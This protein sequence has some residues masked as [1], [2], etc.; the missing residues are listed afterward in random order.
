MT[1]L[2]LEARPIV[3][4]LHALL[5][6]LDPVRWQED[7]EAALGARLEEIREALLRLR[8]L[9]YPDDSLARLQSA[10]SDIEAVL[11]RHKA[12]LSARA[13]T[14]RE[15]WMGFRARLQP[16]YASIASSLRV[17]DVH[18]PA[19]RPTNYKRNALHACAGLGV[20]ALIVATPS[21]TVL[22]WLASGALIYFWT[23]ELLRRRRPKLNAK[24]MAIYGRFAHPHE[25]HR[26]ASSTWYCTS[27]FV[28]AMIGSSVAAVVAIL[29]LALAD[30]AAA[31]VGRRF[32]RIRLLHGR[33]LEG[34]L[35]FVGVG[36]AASALGLAVLFPAVGTGG[37]L[38][39]AAAGSV[40]GGA[41]ELLSRRVDDNLSIPVCAALAA[42]GVALLMGLPLN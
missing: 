10:I 2:A 15:E 18:V 38:A 11:V 3:L 36:G 25:E 21:M 37:I 26:L 12:A 33:S 42:W 29:V 41:A 6:D 31:L 40:A 1:T 34:T 14:T 13:A 28:L 17:L 4:E 5:R 24:L 32:G 23:T 19:L 16:A 35:T 8:T 39:M 22:Q 7:M 30:P 27:L 9:S 20:V